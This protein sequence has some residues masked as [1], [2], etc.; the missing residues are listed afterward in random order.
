MSSFDRTPLRRSI[1]DGKDFFHLSAA[2]S[3]QRS[4]QVH[5]CIGIVHPEFNKIVSSNVQTWILNRDNGMLG[6]QGRYAQAGEA[7]HRR[8]SALAA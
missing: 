1:L 6:V 7:L 5:G 3:V 8:H 2:D 4:M